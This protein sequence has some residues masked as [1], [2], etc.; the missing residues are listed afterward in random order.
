MNAEKKLRKKKMLIDKYVEYNGDGNA[1][2]EMVSG[3]NKNR[4]IVLS[5]GQ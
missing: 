4:I 1:R 3:C 5:L 2:H